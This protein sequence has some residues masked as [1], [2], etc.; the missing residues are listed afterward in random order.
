MDTWLLDEVIN[1]KRQMRELYRREFLEKVKDALN[2][3]KDKI[4]FDEAY[5]FGSLVKPY[6][7]FAFSDIDICFSG[8]DKH[9]F[10]K[11]WAELTRELSYDNIQIIRIEEIDFKEKILKE[12]V[13]WRKKD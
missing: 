5:I 8:L 7:Y 13:R 11:A 6:Q 4:N 1:K 12:A 2:T 10:F 9:N 3:L